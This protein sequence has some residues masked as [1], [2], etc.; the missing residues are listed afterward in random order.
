MKREVT[1][2]GK[3]TYRGAISDGVAYF[4][5]YFT[6][7][8]LDKRRQLGLDYLLGNTDSTGKKILPSPSIASIDD[9]S[10]CNSSSSSVSNYSSGFA[11]WL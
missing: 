7:N 4:Q 9:C 1:K 3:Q 10:S 11:V 8:Y 6:N 2:S 5:R